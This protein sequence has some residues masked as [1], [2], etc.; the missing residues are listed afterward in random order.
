MKS[1]T[2]LLIWLNENWATL[3]TIVILFIGLVSK[4]Y[5]FYKEWQTKTEAE[6]QIEIENAI[7]IARLAIAE[8]ILIY[9][10]DAEVNWKT[11]VKM[12]EIKRAEVINKLYLDYPILLQV[13]DQDELLNYIDNLIDKALETVREKIRDVNQIS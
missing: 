4:G 5:K 8:Q 10:S 7:K 6:K 2:N 11:W 9:V 3:I 13:V 1:I 12:G